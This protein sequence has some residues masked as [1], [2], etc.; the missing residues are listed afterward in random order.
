[1]TSQFARLKQNKDLL[2]ATARSEER[3][4]VDNEL[5]FEQ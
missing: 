4:G 2:Q 5:F 3:E 1:M